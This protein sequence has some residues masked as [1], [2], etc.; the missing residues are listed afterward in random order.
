MVEWVTRIRSLPWVAEK[1]IPGFTM[2][3]IWSNVSKLLFWEWSQEKFVLDAIALALII[4]ISYVF[5]SSSQLW[6]IMWSLPISRFIIS[7]RSCNSLSDPQHGVIYPHMCKSYPVSG[8]LCKFECKPGYQD[9]GGM[10][11]MHCGNDGQWN[12]TESLLECSGN[13]FSV[14]WVQFFRPYTASNWT[15][16]YHFLCLEQKEKN[17][18][19][20]SVWHTLG[21]CFK[22]L[23]YDP[24]GP[25]CAVP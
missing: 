17:G 24:S 2:T 16:D 12:R 11:E 10:T 25:A 8:T 9:N 4:T 15:G 5:A 23:L 14:I 13:F 20:Q 22:C 6:H 21:H 1:E 7:V 19:R 3:L 18:L